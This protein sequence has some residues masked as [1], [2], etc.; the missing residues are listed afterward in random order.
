MN[1]YFNDILCQCLIRLDAGDRERERSREI[2]ITLNLILIGG[3]VQKAS[4]FT[5]NGPVEPANF[6]CQPSNPDN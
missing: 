5:S 2:T 4:A 1:K 3:R 6:Q